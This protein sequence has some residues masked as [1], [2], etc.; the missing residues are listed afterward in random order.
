MTK[1]I[2]QYPNLRMKDGFLKKVRRILRECPFDI[3][4]FTRTEPELDYA[5][6]RS[7]RYLIKRIT[8]SGKSKLSGMQYHYHLLPADRLGCHV[9]CASASSRKFRVLLEPVK[10][11]VLAKLEDLEHSLWASTCKKRYFLRSCKGKRG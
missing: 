1:V 10:A 5:V 2:Y 4:A 6:I 11:E 7:K 9:L 3:V 8:V